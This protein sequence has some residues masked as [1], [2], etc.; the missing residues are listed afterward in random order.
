MARGGGAHL[1]VLRAAGDERVVRCHVQR[2]PALAHLPHHPRHLPIS[3]C[4]K[5]YR[6][7][8]YS[9]T[10]NHLAALPGGDVLLPTHTTRDASQRTRRASELGRC[11]T[12]ILPRD[13]HC[14]EYRPCPS[15]PSSPSPRSI[16]SRRG[17]MPPPL[18]R[19]VRL[20]C[21]DRE[22]AVQAATF[23]ARTTDRS[24]CLERSRFWTCK[25]NPA[26]SIRLG[27]VR[28]ASSCCAAFRVVWVTKRIYPRRGPIGGGTRGYTQGGDQS[29]EGRVT[30]PGPIVARPGML[31]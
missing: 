19:L 24:G 21:E 28:G 3:A 22:R 18:A 11:D 30:A 26:V 9:L 1:R 8:R 6:V 5:V 15:R 31:R 14:D 20:R 7:Y 4:D 16:G 25:T 13:G 27:I 17:Y 2:N 23:V 10:A 29:E 12:G